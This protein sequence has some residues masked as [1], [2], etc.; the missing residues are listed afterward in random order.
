MPRRGLEWGGE[1]K[2]RRKEGN[3]WKKKKERWV[4]RRRGRREMGRIITGSL[5]GRG[6]EKDKEL[7]RKGTEGKAQGIGNK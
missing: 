7:V 1:V 6:E 5:R 2:K 3:S 4:R